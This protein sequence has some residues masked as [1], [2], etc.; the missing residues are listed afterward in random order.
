MS[1]ETIF[2]AAL[3]KCDAAE[4]SA[5]LDEACAGDPALRQRVEALLRSHDEAGPF[6]ERPALARVGE[7]QTAP[8]GPAGEDLPL[9]FLAPSERPGAL[10]RLGH[11]DVLAVVGRGGRG[12]VLKAFD[13]AL[14]RVVAVKVMAPQLAV[15]AS[16]RKRFIR[17]AQAAAAVRDE[18]VIDIH[19]VCDNAPVPYLV[20]EYID[21]QSLEALLR[22]GGPLGV[23]EV[24]RIGLQA[25][26]GLAAAH[27][28]GLV[29]R[30]VKPA[31]ILLENGVERVKLTDFG[32][33]RAADDA[34]LTQSGLIAGTPMY[35]SPEQASGAASTLRATTRDSLLSRARRTTPVPPRP[36][37]SR[38]S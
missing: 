13:E 29:H 35:M 14:Q 6:L 32:L 12:V 3:D 16:A 11:Y 22:K 5:Y 34:S 9:D 31:N 7:T 27:K 20:M 2:L 36:T 23:K 30:D 18:H 37:T 21:G 17:E 24:L 10:G 15:A 26:S 28:Q 25:A 33:A 38:T 19:A 1:E 4:R 8:G